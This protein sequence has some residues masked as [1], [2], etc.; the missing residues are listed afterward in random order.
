MKNIFFLSFSLSSNIYRLFID[1]FMNIMYVYLI[2][3]FVFFTF[4][5]VSILIFFLLQIKTLSID[6]RDCRK[7]QFKI[8]N[9]HIGMTQQSN[10]TFVSHTL[11]SFLDR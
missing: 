9:K 11:I 6:R 5:V 4:D 8:S 2:F 3:I 10:F 7:I 1:L